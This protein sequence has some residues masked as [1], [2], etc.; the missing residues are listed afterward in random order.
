MFLKKK[1]FLNEQSRQD[2]NKRRSSR[3]EKTTAE[4]K[5]SQS[6]VRLLCSIIAVGNQWMDQL[7]LQVLC[8]A[9]AGCLTVS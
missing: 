9:C 4:S 3:P 1:I 8:Q 5:V 6:H 2:E 7:M